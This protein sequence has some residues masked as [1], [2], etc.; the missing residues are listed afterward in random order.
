MHVFEVNRIELAKKKKIN[1][2]KIKDSKKLTAAECLTKIFKSN[3]FSL[4]IIP[5]TL[6]LCLCTFSS[7]RL[8]YFILTK[9]N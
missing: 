4:N 5:I 8:S 1:V 7:T 2:S 3:I 6:S 9:Y